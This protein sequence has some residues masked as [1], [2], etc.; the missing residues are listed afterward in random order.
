M[1]RAYRK[2]LSSIDAVWRRR[3]I[4]ESRIF[5]AEW[6]KTNY[7]D[8]GA[9]RSDPI[10]HYLQ[11]GARLGCR[12][13]LLF[14]PAWYE[15]ARG[16]E[17]RDPNPL[18]DYIL[19]GAREGVEPSPY[20]ST[21]FYRKI[22]GGL[23]RLTPLGHFVAHGSSNNLIPTPLFDRHWYLENNPDVR[24]AGFDPFLHFVASGARDGRSP[25]PLF[26]SA[27]YRMKNADARDE[28]FEPL[29]HYLAIGAG[30]GRILRPALTP[31]SSL[32]A[33]LTGA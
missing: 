19:H 33:P 15:A 29:Y 9:E 14:D 24:Q 10:S 12:P 27:W 30:E 1:S 18:I 2:L 8:V 22:C 16:S 7:P 31:I 3:L 23:G 11:K 28:G 5:D 25:S 6:Y 17:R 13:H 32:Q 21:P 20:F 26:D 4:A